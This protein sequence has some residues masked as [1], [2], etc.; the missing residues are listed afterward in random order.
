MH[1]HGDPVVDYKKSSSWLSVPP[2]AY[3]ARG[4]PLSANGM[5]T[6]DPVSDAR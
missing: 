6:F 2:G 3:E 5:A 1:P 4:W